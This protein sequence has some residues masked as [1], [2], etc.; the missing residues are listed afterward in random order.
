MFGGFQIEKA[1]FK[2]VGSTLEESGWTGAPAEFI[3]ILPDV[4]D[5]NALKA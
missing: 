1:A 3:T 5:I 2:S 4:L